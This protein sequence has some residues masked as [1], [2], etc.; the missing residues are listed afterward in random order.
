MKNAG[1]F[2][3]L[4][5]SRVESGDEIL[6]EHFKTVPR[7][8]TYR[9]KTIENHLQCYHKRNKRSKVYEAVDRIIKNRFSC[10]VIC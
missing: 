6:E 5:D 8:A 1:N 9:S 4:L 10:S 2:Q 3:A 7:T